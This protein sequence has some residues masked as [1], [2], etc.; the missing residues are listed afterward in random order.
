MSNW[1]DRWQLFCEFI[2]QWSKDRS[3]Q[4]GAVIVNDRMTVLASGWNGF[5]RGVNDDINIRHERPA[6]YMWTEHAERNAIYNA[7]AEGIRLKGATM[8]VPWHPC[9]DCA[10]AIIQ[11]GIATLVCTRPKIDDPY[12]GDS[13]YVANRMLI[14]AGVHVRYVEAFVKREGTACVD[15]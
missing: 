8:Y 14:E 10:R 2:S 11:S 13:F 15:S 1:D 12:W 3:T 7:A 6:K 4:V 9:A 5:P